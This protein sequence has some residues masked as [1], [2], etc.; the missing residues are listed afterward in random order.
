MRKSTKHG[1]DMNQPKPQKRRDT[2]QATGNRR[3][4][5]QIRKSLAKHYASKYRVR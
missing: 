5:D 4:A 3:L 2:A 1:P